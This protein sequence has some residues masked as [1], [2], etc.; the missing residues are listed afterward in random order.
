[1]HKHYLQAHIKK[2]VIDL[3]DIMTKF[4]S[5]KIVII[6]GFV[7]ISLRPPFCHVVW[8]ELKTTGLKFLEAALLQFKS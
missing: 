7:R 2:F 1:M 8:K 4:E 5:A 3:G 6:W